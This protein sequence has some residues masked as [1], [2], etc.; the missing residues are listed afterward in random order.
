MVRKNPELFLESLTPTPYA[1]TPTQPGEEALLQQC[2]GR[3][4]QEFT[5]RLRADTEAYLVLRINGRPLRGLQCG[6]K[7]TKCW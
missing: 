3:A 7:V 4:P 5:P 2:P 1:R 6:F